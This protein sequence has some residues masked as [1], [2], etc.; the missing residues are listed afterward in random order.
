MW[1]YWRRHN[2]TLWCSMIVSFVSG[3]ASQK[4]DEIVAATQTT[5]ASTKAPSKVPAKTKAKEL[6][7]ALAYT[8]DGRS[9]IVGKSFQ[10]DGRW[11]GV[12]EIWNARQRTRRM[13]I[14]AI[15]GHADLAV[16]SDSRRFAVNHEIRSTDDGRVIRSFPVS[17]G[18]PSVSF[19]STGKTLLIGTPGSF[20]QFDCVTGASRQIRSPY[21][22]NS[23]INSPYINGLAV[24]SGNRLIAAS[25]YDV[26]GS[27]RVWDFKTTK[28]LRVSGEGDGYG[29]TFTRDGKI[30]AAATSAGVVLWDS[31]SGKVI[32]TLGKESLDQ[33]GS[34][35][36]AISP[37]GR[38]IV[39]AGGWKKRNLRIWN[40]K[41]G[42]LLSELS[43]TGPL[44]FSPDG[45]VLA[46]GKNEG[47]EL[48]FL[49]IAK[50]LRGK[51]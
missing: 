13:R 31:R 25:V 50:E 42:K 32:R 49:A 35:E 45:K 29:V 3:C 43:G 44:A 24:S 6:F 14:P 16:A 21:S 39:D 10:A 28:L 15:E 30:I 46:C 41:T 26:V 18:K 36:I 9:L 12:L 20:E 17:G 4:P 34:R 48:Q 22:F 47:Q 51:L 11:Q 5:I 37:D 38:L 19:D 23:K 27:I 1:N 40:I 7:T 8:P 2:F 33:A